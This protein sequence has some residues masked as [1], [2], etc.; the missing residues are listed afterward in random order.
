M[1]LAHEI[2]DLAFNCFQRD[3]TP[4]QAANEI[5]EM[6]GEG[7]VS[8][9]TMQYWYRKLE[10]GEKEVFL[11]ERPKQRSHHKRKRTL[12]PSAASSGCSQSFSNALENENGGAL[13]DENYGIFVPLSSDEVPQQWQQHGMAPKRTK[14]EITTTKAATTA[15]PAAVVPSLQAKMDEQFGELR[16]EIGKIKEQQSTMMSTIMQLQMLL[17]QKKN[18]NRQEFTESADHSLISAMG[19]Q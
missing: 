15:A 14:M 3:L 2:R 8:K 16:A 4:A 19:G 18:E 13:E 12:S 1:K 17:L 7:S 6:K 9:R 11:M 5:N 10:R